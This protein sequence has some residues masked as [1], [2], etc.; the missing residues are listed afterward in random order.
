M[1]PG[2]AADL[3]DQPDARA[4]QQPGIDGS[5]QFVIGQTGQER[6][7]S[8]QREEGRVDNRAQ[9]DGSG[10]GFSHHRRTQQKQ[11]AVRCKDTDV[12]RQPEQPLKNQTDTGHTAGNQSVGD[13]KGSSAHR[14]NSVSENH[15]TNYL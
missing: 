15:K 9:N 6:D 7:F 8:K 10:K 5:H 1:P 2:G 14:K 12:Y 11:Y 4:H 3:D 13:D